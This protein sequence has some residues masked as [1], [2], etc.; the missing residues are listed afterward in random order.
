M[1][2]CFVLLDKAGVNMFFTMKLPK[3]G[4]HMDYGV[5]DKL[6]VAEN[7]LI[8][9]NQKILD[10]KVDLSLIFAH[11]CP[12]VNYYRVVSGQRA[13]VRKLN[14]TVGDAINV[15][16]EIALFSTE[17]GEAPSSEFERQLIMSVIGIIP[18][19]IW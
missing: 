10:L 5:V 3:L 6:Y 9:A 17:I 18:E 19:E 1:I 16:D 13:Y 12:P 14:V 8:I 4:P 7:D 15:G 11:D 2:S